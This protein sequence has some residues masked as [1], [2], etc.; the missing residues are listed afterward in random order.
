MQTHTHTHTHTHARVSYTCT[1]FMPFVCRPAPRQRAHLHPH[2]G[3][4]PRGLR[5]TAGRRPACGRLHQGKR[6]G[7]HTSSVFACRVREG[8][9]LCHP[10]CIWSP[11]TLIE[12]FS[13]ALLVSSF[14]ADS[15]SDRGR[16][17]QLHCGRQRLRR[18]GRAR[19]HVRGPAGT[20]STVCLE[21]E[22]CLLSER[23]RARA[24]GRALRALVGRPSLWHAPCGLTSPSP[25][26]IH[27]T[28]CPFALPLPRSYIN[29][30][31]GALGNRFEYKASPRLPSSGF[32][33]S[34][35]ESLTTQA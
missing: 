33:Y 32:S 34:C 30:G 9:L 31:G 28:A 29:S 27:C 21:D 18:S 15:P 14:H 12:S 4:P 35:S 7:M 10:P 19:P 6:E 22:S 8:L 2:L 17:R 16:V 5:H 26:S 1:R 13:W 24:P 11:C 23:A 20:C 3:R 25:L